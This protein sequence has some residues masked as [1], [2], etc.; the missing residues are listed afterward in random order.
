MREISQSDFPHLKCK[1]SAGG[2]LKIKQTGWR[3]DTCVE[4]GNGLGAYFTGCPSCARV[5]VSKPSE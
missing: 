1:Y 3:F 5:D 2:M 4:G